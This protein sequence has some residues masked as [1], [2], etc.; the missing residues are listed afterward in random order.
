M[1]IKN[2][3]K[4]ILSK[5]HSHHKTEPDIFIFTLP[6]AGSTLLAE[7]IN[8]IPNIKLA[9]E[10]FA[11]NK[12]N[13]QV[14]NKYFQ[15]DFISERYVDVSKANL[16]QVYHY[17]NDLSNGNNWNGYYWSDFFKSHHNF[18]TTRTCFK[19]HKF[20]YHFDDIMSNF[21]DDF[22]IYLLRNP[23][24]HSLSRINKGWNTY[25]DLYSESIKIK[26]I[27]PKTAL[28]IIEQI[29]TN[30]TI[31]EKFVVSWC[32]ENYVFINKYQNNKLPTNVILVFY[33]DLI[34]DSEN[35][36]KDICE[37]TKMDY[38][39]NMVEI[40]DVPSSGIIHS[41]KE[42]EAQILSGNKNYLV[43]RWKE[44]IDTNTIKNIKKILLCFEIK[45]YLDSFNNE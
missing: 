22:C 45:L 12:D 36:I 25:I 1:R 30:G 26:N 17:Y 24:S 8:S 34:L 10:S 44:S 20:N 39:E 7:I 6:R 41:T 21:K 32:L 37:K 40:I 15:Q 3:I 2:I 38:K 31:L 33:E 27:L 28:Y 14:L 13:I 9:S 35:C 5:L 18:K 19:T 4:T 43:N 29:N 23:V 42:T 16:K 11:L